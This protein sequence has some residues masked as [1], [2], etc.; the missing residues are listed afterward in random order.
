MLY[1]GI[2]EKA[3]KD[4]STRKWGTHK[5]NKKTQDLVGG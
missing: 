4:F 3:I 2:P 5:I 1:P